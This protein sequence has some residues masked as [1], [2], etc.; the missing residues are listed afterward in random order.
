MPE[1]IKR[2]PKTVMGKIQEREH[3]DHR[4]DSRQRELEKTKKALVEENYS[5]PQILDAGTSPLD[6]YAIT[7]IP[8][9]MLLAPD[10]TILA[11]NLRGM[12]IE[13]TIQEHINK[14]TQ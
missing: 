6:Q 11:R 8:H 13:K 5:W 12:Q 1:R 7:G 3:A 14:N 4:G 10:G 2:V 9:I